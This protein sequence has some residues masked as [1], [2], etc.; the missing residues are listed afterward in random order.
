MS[1]EN[2]KKDMHLGMFDR[3]R[4]DPVMPGDVLAAALSVLWVIVC[5]VFFFLGRRPDSLIS[6]DTMNFVITVLAVVLPIALIWVAA[7]AAR[8]VSVVREESM[9]LQAAMDVLRQNYVELTQT[10]RLQISQPPAKPMQPSVP[11]AP[12]S[13]TAQPEISFRTSRIAAQ[14]AV[15]EPEF[16]LGLPD[17]AAIPSLSAEEFIRA[18]NFPKTADDRAGFRALKRALSDPRL[19]PIIQASQ[20]VLTLLSQDGIYMDDLIPDRARPDIWRK[21]AEGQRGR[22][23][24][25]LG[26]VRDRNSL[27]LAAQRM[28]SD[29]IFRDTAHHFL[30]QFDKVFAAFAPDATD[31]EIAA[32]ADTR[33]ARAFML[34]G[35]V[36]GTFD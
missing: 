10:K 6:F 32:L 4:R 18:F 29:H 33:T 1:D 13:Q 3:P 35:R 19:K 20:D 36:A 17:Q 15:A 7:V 25:M 24:A 2:P 11:S 21:F 8:S 9:R 16:A 22:A 31:A 26:G 34:L 5:G 14:S 27:S 23:I 12:K 28:R 30:R